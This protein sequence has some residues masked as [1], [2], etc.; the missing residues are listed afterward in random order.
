MAKVKELFLFRVEQKDK[1]KF[2]KYLA[3]TLYKTDVSLIK[4]VDG[5]STN[6][7]QD[8]IIIN[9]KPDLNKLKEMRDNIDELIKNM[10][11]L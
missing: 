9:S 11:N 7:C 4:F 8:N 6:F 2:Q 3:K 5:N 1:K 10:Q